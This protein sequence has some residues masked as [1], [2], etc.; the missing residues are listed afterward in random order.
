MRPLAA[1]S[2][3]LVAVAATALFLTTGPATP[4]RA[5]QPKGDDPVKTLQKERLVLLQ[6]IYDLSLI[7][8]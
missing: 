3:C 2:L 8:I 7:H 5:N 6:K 4:S 1:R